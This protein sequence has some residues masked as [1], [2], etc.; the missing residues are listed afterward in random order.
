M[1]VNGNVC[2]PIYFSGQ[3]LANEAALM[4]P[5]FDQLVMAGLG[6]GVVARRILECLPGAIFF[7]CGPV[8]Q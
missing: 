3:R 7:K 8:F 1:D 5:G 4:T 2:P 6:S